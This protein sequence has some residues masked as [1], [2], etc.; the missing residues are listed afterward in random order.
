[1]HQ[2]LKLYILGKKTSSDLLS[3]FILWKEK[4]KSVEYNM[5][6]S[7]LIAD[8]NDDLLLLLR[9]TLE[10]DGYNV[11]VAKDGRGALNLLDKTHPELMLLDVMM[12]D[13]DGLEVT[14]RIRSNAELSDV[15]VLLVSANHEITEQEVD[16]SGANGIIYKPYLLN[17]V[18]ERVEESLL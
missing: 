9:L 11:I 3:I 14:R 13:L 2:P 16:R 12:P 5:S 10:S 1:M 18:L 8:D 7:I 17:S 4:T 6:N 15:P